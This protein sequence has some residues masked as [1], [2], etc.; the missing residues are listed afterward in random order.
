M[1][2]NSS[3]GVRDLGFGLLSL[4]SVALTLIAQFVWMV[5]FD[6]SGLDVYAPDLLFM[7]I[8]PAFTLALIPTVAAQYLYTQKWSLITGGVVFVASAIVSTFTIQFFILCSPGC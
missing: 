7:H 3:I 5:I 8:L 6:S 4:V 2:A 1:A